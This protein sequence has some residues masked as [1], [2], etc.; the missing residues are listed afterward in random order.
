MRFQNI[1]LFFLL[2]SL[3]SACKSQGPSTTNTLEVLKQLAPSIN[4]NTKAVIVVD[5]NSCLSC[6]QAF[7]GIIT[8][9]IG[10]KDVAFIV[11]ANPNK[12]DISPFLVPGLHNVFN[13]YSKKLFSDK[14]I[15]ASTVF[16]LH[17]NTIDTTITINPQSVG[18]IE[19][20]MVKKIGG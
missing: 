4:N 16:I 2:L 10:R 11:S 13:D 19:D 7:A 17:H 6:N 20:F 5:D 12:V 14:I 8:K 18:K 1:T 3:C 9:F 15:T